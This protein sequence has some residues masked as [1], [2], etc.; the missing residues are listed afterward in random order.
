MK[1]IRLSV[2]MIFV[3]LL[4]SCSSSPH[5]F[6]Q[7]LD[8]LKEKFPTADITVEN[9]IL[10]MKQAVDFDSSSLPINENSCDYIVYDR[11]DYLK[12]DLKLNRDVVFLGKK[13]S[14]ST[15]ITK[16]DSQMLCTDFYTN[17]PVEVVDVYY[18]DIEKGE[19]ITLKED[20]AILTDETG[21]ESIQTYGI[22][23]IKGEQEYIFILTKVPQ[24]T[25]EIDKYYSYMS[26]C[27]GELTIDAAALDFKSRESYLE[28]VDFSMEELMADL[29]E[30]YY[31]KETADLRL[32]EKEECRKL[33]DPFTENEAALRKDPDATLDELRGALDK[34]RL[35]LL[36]RQ[37]A[38]YG[39]K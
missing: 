6:K 26:G 8:T 13:R 1:K 9:D 16:F 10:T 3:L 38:Q 27:L 17:T 34:E 14:Q 31:N 12:S 7:H 4:V 30:N 18:G 2:C 35:S 21:T 37:L 36:D 11:L 39:Q 5:P 23:P 33:L 32:D 25:K 19:T 29:L 28:K 24:E 22:P 15:Q 20:V